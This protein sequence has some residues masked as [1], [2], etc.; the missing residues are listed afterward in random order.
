M[1]A[2]DSAVPG[3]VSTT[4][5]ISTSPVRSQFQARLSFGCTK[6]ADWVATGGPSE[7][8]KVPVAGGEVVVGVP[9][10]VASYRDVPAAASA[11]LDV[12]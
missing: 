8:A 1:Y 4:I 9:M 7:S 12:R 11:L 6:H 2:P 5:D 3:E 10:R